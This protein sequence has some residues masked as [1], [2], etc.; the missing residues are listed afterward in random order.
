M[1]STF[2]LTPA[3][4][5]AGVLDY[6]KPEDKKLYNKA[7]SRMYPEDQLFDCTPGNM[8]DFLKVLDRR[9]DEYG[10]NNEI[11]GILWIPEDH[12]NVNAEL[13][14]L[15]KEYGKISIE[16]IKLFEASY[17]DEEKRVAQD[18]Y[19]LYHC[20][21]NSLTKE[22]RIK[23]QMWEQEY[24]IKNDQGTVVPSGNLLLKVIIRESHLDT[25]ATMAR[26]MC[27]PFFSK[28]HKIYS[29]KTDICC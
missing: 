1:T 5:F 24:I 16:R 13:H 6:S 15:P 4:A 17:L 21:L 3:G 26:E 19:M 22:A 9:A 2:S 18:S 12:K 10:W 14:Y 7:T 25:N 23:V 28:H 8:H 29:L 20:L 27:E 11:T